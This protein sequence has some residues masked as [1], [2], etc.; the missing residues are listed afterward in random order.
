MTLPYSTQVNWYAHAQINWHRRRND[1]KYWFYCNFDVVYSY[2]NSLCVKKGPFRRINK[3]WIFNKIGHL[4]FFTYRL[5]IFLSQRWP[6]SPISSGV[7]FS[8]FWRGLAIPSVNQRLNLSE[9]KCL[10]LSERYSPVLRAL[11]ILQL[12]CISWMMLLLIHYPHYPFPPKALLG[13][14]PFSFLPISAQG[15][16]G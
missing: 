5:S 15:T 10:N 8:L 14:P 4:N 2:Q 13:K 12:G 9:R 7:Y 16:I 11:C 1:K 6:Y 3:F